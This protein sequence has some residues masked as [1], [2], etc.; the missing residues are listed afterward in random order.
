MMFPQ[1]SLPWPPTGM[2]P[3]GS[4]GHWSAK[5]KSAKCYKDA[6]AWILRSKGITRVDGHSADLTLT[7]C[8]PSLRKYDLDNALARAKQ[9]LDAIAEAIGIDDSQ[10]RSITL[11]RGEKCRDGA[12][13]VIIEVM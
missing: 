4:H 8:P 9:G 5:S 10:W 1:F 11:E 3:N 12:I 13:I 7:F 6:C 2:S